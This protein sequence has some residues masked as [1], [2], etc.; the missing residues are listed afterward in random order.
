MGE[1]TQ[2]FKLEFSG[3][4]SSIIPLGG[5]VLK[6]RMW[7][8]GDIFVNETEAKEINISEANEG[9]HLG[10]TIQ[11]NYSVFKPQWEIAMQKARH[12]VGLV[13]LLARRCSNPLTVMKPL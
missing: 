10:I 3:A 5:P 8:M 4:K 11:K 12:G 9:R 2:Q 7:K 13:T 1:Y 6:D